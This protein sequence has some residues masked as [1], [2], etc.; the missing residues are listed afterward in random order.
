MPETLTA[1]NAERPT[2]NAPLR[3]WITTSYRTYKGKR[4]GPY[5]Y[6]KWKVGNRTFKQYIKPA[7]LEKTK[8]ACRQNREEAIRKRA[9]G[10]RWTTFID[11]AAFLGKMNA[12]FDRNEQPRKDQA[13][14]I[15]RLHHEGMFISG[16]PNYRLK[17]VFGA[18][19]FSKPFP[20]IW[21][22]YRDAWQGP[23]TPQDLVDAFQADCIN[24]IARRRRRERNHIFRLLLQARRDMH[25]AY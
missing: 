13:D 16:R 8:A 25:L 2:P 10:R 17:R 22:K 24:C 23:Y 15:V 7:D 12:T 4:L 9:E 6:R 18:P 19:Y 14:Y 20:H 21:R 1:P 3:G 5:H 11:N